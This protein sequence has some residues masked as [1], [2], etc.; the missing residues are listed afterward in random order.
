VRALLA[1]V[2]LFVAFSAKAAPVVIRPAG[3]PCQSPVGNGCQAAAL[4][5]TQSKVCIG[6]TI[7]GTTYSDIRPFY[8]ELG[9]ASG[10]MMQ[11][12]VGDGT[13][14]GTTSLS[15]ASASKMISEIDA[16]Q[17]IGGSSLTSAQI[18]AMNFTDGYAN[19]G[20]VT[21][22]QTC[23]VNPPGNTYACN[24]SHTPSNGQSISQCLTYCSSSGLNFNAVTA[25]SVGNFNYDSGHLQ[26]LFGTTPFNSFNN[27]SPAA[28]FPAILSTLGLT[29]KTNGYLNQPLMAGGVYTTGQ[30]YGVILANVLNGTGCAGPYCTASP[31]SIN[32]LGWIGTNQVTAYCTDGSGHYGS[33]YCPSAVVVYSPIINAWKYGIGGW[34]EI[35]TT[36]NND[37]SVSSPGAFGFYPWLQPVCPA[38][39]SA[40][41][42]ASATDVATAITNAGGGTT[43]NAAIYRFYGVLS[44][45]AKSGISNGTAQ[46][47][48]SAACAALIRAAWET[49]VQQTGKIPT[50]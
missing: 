23:P 22:V 42:C 37:F 50:L 40:P 9:S 28:I 31:S 10:P 6:G 46:G 16:V 5:A 4:T 41:F 26:N 2:L 45:Y 36:Q 39:A 30:H 47:Q 13:V 7:S 21:N 1:A 19:M 24:D 44:R 29:G 35:V 27:S 32:V 18:N 49:G 38:G 48:K 8:F 11:M 34:D 14:Q 17:A 12:A 3:Q 33:T 20:D 15:I 43:G 25:G